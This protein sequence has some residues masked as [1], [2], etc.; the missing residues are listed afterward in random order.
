MTYKTMA[1]DIARFIREHHLAGCTVIGHS[2]GGS[3][4]IQLAGDYP[5]LIKAAVI[6]DSPI[7]GNDPSEN[8][9]CRLL[10]IAMDIDLTRHSF[11]SASSE[12]RKRITS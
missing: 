10:K 12:I 2:M 5:N 3:T 7:L 4:A 11:H 9:N 8:E 6:M 1:S